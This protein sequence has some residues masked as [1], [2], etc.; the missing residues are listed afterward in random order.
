[1]WDPTLNAYFYTFTPLRDKEGVRGLGGNGTFSPA[2]PSTPV[3]FL[4]FFGRWGD[5][6]YSDDD[7]RQRNLAGLNITYKFESGPEGPAAKGLDRDDVCPGP[8]RCGTL[9]ELPP[10]SGSE[11]PVT[12][13]RTRTGRGVLEAT[14]TGTPSA[15]ASEATQTGSGAVISAWASWSADHPVAF[16]LVLCAAIL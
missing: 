9:T 15:S 6:R 3:G 12:M 14:T 1:M 11:L 7:P 4:Y 2:N 5:K 16:T 10:Q 8:G 13:T